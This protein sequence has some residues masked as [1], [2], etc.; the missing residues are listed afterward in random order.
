[1]SLEVID[2]DL[3]DP[4]PPEL[5]S[6]DPERVSDATRYLCAGAY[7]DPEFRDRCLREVYYQ[8]KRI[9][10]PSYGFDLVTV[11]DACLRA[12]TLAVFRDLTILIVLSIAAV[13]AMRRMAAAREADA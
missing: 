11:L 4:E 3:V 10:A 6:G 1:M 2:L 5:P 9:V 13:F 7:L 12:R 8:F